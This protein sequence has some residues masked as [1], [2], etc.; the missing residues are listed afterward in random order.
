[1]NSTL[2][3]SRRRSVGLVASDLDW[4]ST[5]AAILDERVRRSRAAPVLEWGR[6]GVDVPLVGEVRV[7]EVIS[8]AVVVGVAR[9][10]LGRGRCAYRSTG[11]AGRSHEEVLHA[12]A[13]DV[14]GA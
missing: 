1:M 12:L 2:C 11:K 13:G 14:T 10:G 6:T 5:G 4:M 8:V 7:G 9:T 3:W